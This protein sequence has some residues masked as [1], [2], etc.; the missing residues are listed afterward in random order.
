MGSGRVILCESLASYI[1]LATPPSDVI[2]PFVGAWGLV[3]NHARTQD[4]SQ[5][6]WYHLYQ[7]FMPQGLPQEADL[8]YQV[9][10]HLAKSTSLLRSATFRHRLQRPLIMG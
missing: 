4:K 5:T 3:L 8:F 1:G 10:H 6:I 7:N 2:E 9:I